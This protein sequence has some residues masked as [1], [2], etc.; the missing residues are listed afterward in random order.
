MK[1]TDIMILLLAIGG[2]ASG[3]VNTIQSKEIEELEAR[4]EALELSSG[5][6]YE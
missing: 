3:I 1:L 4:I 5:E 6:E 2:I